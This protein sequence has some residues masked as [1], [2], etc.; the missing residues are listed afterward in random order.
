M[1]VF[2]EENPVAKREQPG[3]WGSRGRVWAPDIVP[4]AALWERTLCPTL[5]ESQLQKAVMVHWRQPS[6]EGLPLGWS[7][8][9]CTDLCIT[10]DGVEE[11]VIC[12]CLASED[13]HDRQSSHRRPPSSPSFHAIT[14]TVIPTAVINTSII[15][16]ITVV[17]VTFI[18]LYGRCHWLF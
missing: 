4:A 1:S 13:C 9:L 18:C 5:V 8:D 10:S 16:I 6:P 3:L 14:L 11:G 12:S 17:A 15:G 2:E 7:W